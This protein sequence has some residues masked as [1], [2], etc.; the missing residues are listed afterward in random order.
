MVDLDE[1]EV[2]LGW[3]GDLGDLRLCMP[4]VRSFRTAGVTQFIQVTQKKQVMQI[5]QV[6]QDVQ[7]IQITQV[8]PVT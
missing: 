7:V 2:C 5:N 3:E 8:T 4:S 6:T 1:L